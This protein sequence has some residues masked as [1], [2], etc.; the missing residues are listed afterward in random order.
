MYNC[1]DRYNKTVYLLNKFYWYCMVFINVLS[2]SKSCDFGL[3]KLKIDF[4]DI[5]NV[6]LH[7]SKYKLECPGKNTP[8]TKKQNVKYH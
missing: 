5:L 3:K 4:V 7:L 2:I 6:L 1:T 8:G